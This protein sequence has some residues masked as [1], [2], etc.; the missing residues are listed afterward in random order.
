MKR[1]KLVL[2]FVLALTL[3]FCLSACGSE[4]KKQNET[5]TENEDAIS[6]AS[7]LEIPY[8]EMELSEYL[9]L[10]DYDTFSLKEAAP[11]EVTDKD[12]EKEIDG[13]LLSKGKTEE[14]TTGDAQNGDIINLSFSGKLEDGTT[15]DGLS[16]SSLT[17]TLGK[18]D[19]VEGFQEGI[20][21]KSIGKPFNLELTFPEE[22]PVLEAVA[23][24]TVSFN[25]TINYKSVTTPANLDDEFV[26][27]N[28]NVA[29]VAEYKKSIREQLE[30]K[31]YDIAIEEV[32]NDIYSQIE[33]STTMHEIPAERVTEYREATVSRYKKVAEQNGYEWSDFISSV[34]GLTEDDFDIQM[35]QYS[36]EMVKQEMII[37]A[38]A[39]REKIEISEEEFEEYMNQQLKNSGYASMEQFEATAGMSYK[40]YVQKNHLALNAYLGQ[41]LTQ[42]YERL[43]K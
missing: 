18:E 22:Y 13:I 23:G 32:K 42:I 10:P 6:T 19:M 28:S 24:H 7:L 1:I 15:V 5:V 12:V 39:Y 17:I 14:V 40:E 43:S 11:E 30:T 21:G 25:I 31:A 16:S 41:E 2:C 33:Q 9:E 8:S 27:A 20:I 3:S 38:I 36:N 4:D 29:T 37:Y 34:F 35:T 26:K